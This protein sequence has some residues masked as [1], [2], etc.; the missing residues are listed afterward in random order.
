[1][2]D[3]RP[4]TH[5]VPPMAWLA[6]PAMRRDITG[7]RQEHGSSTGAGLSECFGTVHNLSSRVLM[8]VPI[9]LIKVP[10][11]LYLGL[12]FLSQLIVA[13]LGAV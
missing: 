12:W 6:R 11:W 3:L 8:F 9:F 13:N 5:L 1:M 2:G 4:S 7:P 10:A